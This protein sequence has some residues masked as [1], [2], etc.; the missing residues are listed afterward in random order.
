MD[1]LK[2]WKKDEF[3]FDRIA[4]EEAGLPPLDTEPKMPGMEEKANFQEHNFD[5]PFSSPR[6]SMAPQG[7]PFRSES[8]PASPQRDMELINSK[9]DTLKAMLSGMEQRLGTLERAINEKKPPR[10]W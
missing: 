6:Q 7:S 2:F 3:D 1:K 10:V 8:S 5:S 4:S 9:L